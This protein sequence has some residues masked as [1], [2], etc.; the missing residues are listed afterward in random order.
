MNLNP[1]FLSLIKLGFF[2]YFLCNHLAIIAVIII[3]KIPFGLGVT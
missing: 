2:V 3:I 1:V